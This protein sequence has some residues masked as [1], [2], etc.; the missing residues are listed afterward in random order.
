[1]KEKKKKIIILGGGL[2]GLAAADKLAGKYDVTVL[3]KQDYLGGLASSFEHK[4]KWIPRHYHHIFAHDRTTHAYLKRFGLFRDMAWKKIK[5]AICV[6]RRIYNFT[7]PLG[8]LTFDYLSLFGRIRY[9]LFGAYVLKVMNPDRIPDRIDA[10]TWLSRYA[11]KEVTD[12]LFYQLQGRN[13]FGIPLESISA[14]Q[15]AHRLKAGE[16][17]GKFGYPRKGL[18]RMVAGL[19]EDL[20]RKGVEIIRNAKIKNIDAKKRAITC[21]KKKLKYDAVINT[22]PIPEML[23]MTTGLPEG[24]AQRLS[25]IRYCP[26]VTVIFG[27]NRFLSKHY[28][29]NIL[30]ER[31]H[32]LM[33]HSILFDEYDS[34]IVWALRYGNSGKDLP[35][36]DEEI[37]REYLGVV[38]KFFP[39]IKIKWARVFKERYAS[40]I[41]DKDYPFLKPDFRSPVEGFYN[42]G[43]AVSYPKIRNMNTALESGLKVAGIVSKNLG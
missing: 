12:K 18:K 35:L 1:M 16:A 38:R 20:K 37:K 32:M 39:D 6:G 14:R 26:C 30:K 19:E 42:A 24:Y 29:L 11:G 15:F 31:I 9:G 5:M 23:K 25:R 28:W 10:R 8:L 7:E 43:I 13:K 34:K 2:T 22:I 41:Y 33:Q 4:G 21:N 36:S 17:L 40:P 27:A 3:E